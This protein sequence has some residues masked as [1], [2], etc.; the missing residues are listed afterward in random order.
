MKGLKTAKLPTVIPKQSV[1]I[2]NNGLKLIKQ[3]I[4]K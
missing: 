2:Y 1:V 4:R 3:C